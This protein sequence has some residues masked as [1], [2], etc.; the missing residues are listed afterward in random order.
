VK[1]AHP[2]DEPRL[3]E[4][5]Y[6][7]YAALRRRRPVCVVE[8][9]DQ[10][11]LEVLLTAHGAIEAVLRDDRFSVDRRRADVLSGLMAAL[12]EDLRPEHQVPSML[13]VDPPAHERLRRLVSGR[14]TPQRIL[15][16][17]ESIER[18]VAALLDSLDGEAEVDLLRDFARPL[19]VLVIAGLLGLPPEHGPRLR[20]WSETLLGTLLGPEDSLARFRTARA[21]LRRYLGARMAERRRQAGPDLIG[22]LVEAADERDALSEEEV[23][24]T[25]ELLLVAGHETTADLIGNGVA[26]LLRH[27][28]EWDRL[29][30]GE[31]SFE[32]AV[33][34]LLRFE[35]PFQGVGRVT[36]EPLELGG[37]RLPAGTLVSAM[38]GA[39]NRDPE[40]FPEP[41]RLD[42][43]RAPNPHLA[44]G[45]GIHFCL[46]AALARLE[47]RLALEGLAAR[48]PELALAE[49]R[50]GWRAGVSLRGLRRLPVRLRGGF[51][52]RSPAS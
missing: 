41:D 32:S 7:I 11:G 40:V 9:A 52:R 24:A 37:V 29:V 49:R 33:E 36:R 4:D 21:E 15:P 48:F 38:V 16:L 42:V 10:S 25:C 17:A 12:P 28:S 6:P 20:A 18:R 8:R 43:T 34:E 2:F 14:F 47:G 1:R 5:P 45:H 46:G 19:P 23:V 31:A 22:L 30:R 3:V 26:S 27:P 50:L 39:A 35:S 13:T 51:R 44:F